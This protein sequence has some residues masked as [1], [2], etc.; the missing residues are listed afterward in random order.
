MN[1]V[2]DVAV[3]G[4]GMA[5]LATATMIAA[6][7]RSVIVME[8]GTSFG[9]RGI[10]TNRD[11]AMINLGPHAYY[12][13]GAAERVLGHLGIHVQ[14]GVPGLNI[15]WL[16]SDG[17]MTTTARIL[18][19]SKLRWHEKMQIMKTLLHIRRM[20]PADVTGISWDRYLQE[21]GVK[22][23][24]AELLHALA[25]LGTYVGSAERLDA[26]TVVMQ[27]QR[28]TLYPDGGWQSI[29]DSLVEKARFAGV[30]LVTKAGVSSL[31]TLDGGCWKVTYGSGQGHSELSA[32][33]IVCTT[34]PKHL[35]ALAG[36]SLPDHVHA[37]LSNLEPVKV[38]CLDVHLERLPQPNRLFAL[39]TVEPVYL[40][41]HSH[42]A[43]LVNNASEAVIHV[44]YYDVEEEQDG[45]TM[46]DRLEVVLD[47]MQ[48]GWRDQVISQRFM[49]NLT[50]MYARPTPE[51]RGTL[52]RPPVYTGVSGLYAA[53]DWVG[54]EGLLLDASMASSE[55]AARSIL[56]NTDQVISK[57]EIR[58]VR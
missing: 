25:R 17:Q 15:S 36:D 23:R 18:V 27:L 47:K 45:T 29:I 46:R 53:G 56:A 34:S 38:A 19:G 44:M 6:Q 42:W 26:G 48:L 32:R 40:S 22:G 8:R 21:L 51:L 12:R 41:V 43:K 57:P 9:G 16:L 4:G 24:A 14:G 39:G 50:V 7:G 13:G 52:E 2:W 30:Q 55:A 49:P 58:G 37:R 5:G 3:I 11:G 28:A 1:K 33:H 20:N 10:S 31:Q 54:A 35:L